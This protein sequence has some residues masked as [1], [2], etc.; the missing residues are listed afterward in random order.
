MNILVSA[1]SLCNDRDLDPLV[2]IRGILR[3]EDSLSTLALLCHC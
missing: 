1:L 3:W 2:E